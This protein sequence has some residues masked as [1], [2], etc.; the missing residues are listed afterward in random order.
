MKADMAEK[1]LLESKQ[2][3]Y[4][5]ESRERGKVISDQAA[6]QHLYAK[7]LRDNSHQKSSNYVIVYFCFRLKN[8]E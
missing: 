7:Y 4:E 8:E 1:E 2:N 6:V 3:T 5:D